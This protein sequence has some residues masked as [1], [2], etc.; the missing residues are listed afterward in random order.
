MSTA[1]FP[2]VFHCLLLKFIFHRKKS[3]GPET[4]GQKLALI[5]MGVYYN[6]SNFYTV[7]RMKIE[8]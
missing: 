3:P 7:F 4:A 5:A 1:S 8:Q 6:M 2:S